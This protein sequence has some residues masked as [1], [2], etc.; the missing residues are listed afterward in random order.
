MVGIPQGPV[1]KRDV[2]QH[3]SPNPLSPSKR[4]AE[5]LCTEMHT[6]MFTY[7]NN[8]L[9]F[10]EMLQSVYKDGKY[11][12]SPAALSKLQGEYQQRLGDLM[13]EVQGMGKSLLTFIYQGGTP[14]TLSHSF[15]SLP[16]A[17]QNTLIE[18]AKAGTNI[19]QTMTNLYQA[20]SFSGELTFKEADNIHN[21]ELAVL[22]ATNI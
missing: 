20:Y 11:N 18:Y 6:F 19:E 8:P 5:S 17:T 12:I 4:S 14:P 1:P 7:N 10:S 13:D 9:S 2:S 16:A 3:S 22:Q 15:T 21:C